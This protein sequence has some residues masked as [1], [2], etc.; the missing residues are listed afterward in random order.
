M[1]SSFLRN[2]VGCTLVLS[3]IASVRAASNVVTT[4][5]ARVHAVVEH[6][7]AKGTAATRIGFFFELEPHW[8]VYWRN[9]GDSGLPPKVEWLEGSESYR[10]SPIDWPAPKRI[11]LSTLA[12]FGYENEV[13]LPMVVE[14]TGNK[15][16]KLR[17]KLSWLVCKEECIPRE[18]EFS[19]DPASTEGSIQP[20][21]PASSIPP[22]PDARW[23]RFTDKEETFAARIHVPD[24]G[25]DPDA[26]DFFPYEMGLFRALPK[27]GV[28]VTEAPA[29]GS[30]IDFTFEKK[31]WTPG[32]TL[33]SL[34]GLLILNPGTAR[35]IGE[36]TAP[37]PQTSGSVEPEARPLVLLI[38]FALF[39]GVLLN[40]MP[41]VFPILALK[42]FDFAK[43]GEDSKREIRIESLLY[44][45]GVL[46][47]FWLLGGLLLVLRWQGA[48]LGWGFQL[49]SPP[50]V[51][52]LCVL[53]LAMAMN[54][55][56]LFE[57]HV[58]IHG[59][60][61]AR[62]QESRFGAF[63]SGFLTTIVSTPC[64]APFLGAALGASLT[65]PA[66]ASMLIF[67]AMGLGVAAP[68][69]LLVN[70]SKAHRWLPKPGAWMER[71]K[72]TLG[73]FMMGT[74]LWLLWVLGEQRG[75]PSMVL[76]M[77]GLL[78]VSI[79]LWW[80]GG[81]R[82]L[83]AAACALAGVGLLFAAGSSV[84]EKLRWEAFD[85]AKLEEYANGSVPTYVDFTA[86]WCLTCQVNKAVALE[87]DA[88]VAAFQVGKVRLVRADWTERDES[89]AKV[90]AGLG[91]TSVP[92]NV[93]FGPGGRAP[94]ILPT[95]LTPGIVTEY[96]NQRTGGQP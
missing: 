49:Q 10:I 5:E 61:L 64:T 73:F 62:L 40:L 19:I 32:R 71:L 53:F 38:L 96:L 54:F 20:R 67:T 94:A 90:L 44:V 35:S 55:W 6:A 45:A 72:G 2:W 23:D 13:L 88:V 82:R 14:R 21:F 69:A 60:A 7:L 3:S 50:F 87:S 57:I 95:V 79:S 84:E 29:G 75:L 68:Y 92:T 25:L 89:I 74:L 34:P 9:P 24:R 85:A 27:P 48:H 63:F 30:W 39:G 78:F 43:R 83:V 65:L 37:V 86:S 11:A 8:H 80:K 33:E 77:F 51:L 47:S 36:A 15:T 56:G 26:V 58:R 46:V 31:T 22:M 70:L 59:H 18:G 17:A 66:A 28:R 41:C 1:R 4:P 93:I 81:A 76:A 52:A 91:R 16:P 12:N 42:A